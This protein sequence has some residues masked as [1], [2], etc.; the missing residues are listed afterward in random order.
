MVLVLQ[1]VQVPETVHMLVLE[2]VDLQDVD[3]D[4]TGPV[5][6]LQPWVLEHGGSSH[7]GSDAHGHDSEGP[8]DDSQNS[9]TTRTGFCD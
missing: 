7:A 1:L 9:D 5:L 8:A 2:A 3:L 6:Q 4:L